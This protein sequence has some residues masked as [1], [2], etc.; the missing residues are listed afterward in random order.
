MTWQ[1]NNE[2]QP[3][4]ATAFKNTENSYMGRTETENASE[5]SVENTWT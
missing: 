5:Q 2:S 4:P 3:C 1:R